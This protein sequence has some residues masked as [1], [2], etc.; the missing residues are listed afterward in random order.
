VKTLESTSSALILTPE[1]APTSVL[2]RQLLRFAG[3]TMAQMA[4]YTAM[5]FINTLM[6]SRLG[7]SA[8][9]AAL[10][11]GI[12]AFALICLGAGTLVLVN[13]L[14][15]Q[16]FGRG[17]NK[18]CGRHLWQG[19]W[20][21][22]VF[23]LIILPLAAPASALFRLF[24]HTP[25]MVALEAAYFRVTIAGAV[26]QLTQTAM[27]QFLLGTN[28]PTAVLMASI[29]GVSVNA[30]FGWMLIFGYFGIAPKGILGAAW[31]RN[32]GV[33]AELVVQAILILRPQFARRFAALDWRPRPRLF[34]ELLRLGVPSGFQQL[35]ELSA[36]SMFLNVVIGHFGTAAMAANAF[37]LRYMLVSFMP[38][39]GIG[40]AVTALVGRSIGA[41]RPSL[42]VRYANLGFVVAA[43][44]MVCC[45]LFFFV[46]RNSL[47]GFFSHDPE[48]MRIGEVLLVMAAIFQFFDAVCIVYSFALRGAGD[49]LVP[50]V[51]TGVLCWTIMFGA[52]Y[53]ISVHRTQ[54]GPFGPWMAGLVYAAILGLLLW[55]RFRSGGWRSIH[56]EDQEADPNAAG[57]ISDAVPTSARAEPDAVAVN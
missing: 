12:F 35:A 26:L 4:A 14:T 30:L 33:G 40:S 7:T 19:I 23:A 45:G 41:R 46:A 18:Q 34:A 1:D 27:S 54:W 17:D 24:H 42:A 49:T 47:I 44:Y 36:W 5:E 52:G 11:A 13:T 28:R 15:S 57:L 43:T 10:N 29:I 31:A 9:A 50:A 37:M 20:F 21:S 6:L 22:L 39:V 51:A 8:P 38:A 2:L 55:A 53:W 56:L 3:P 16:S 32:I 25:D 48:V